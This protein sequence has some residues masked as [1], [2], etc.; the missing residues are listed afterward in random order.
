MTESSEK[1]NGTV[2]NTFDGCLL[3]FPPCGSCLCLLLASYFFVRLYKSHSFH[4][5]NLFASFEIYQVVSHIY[6]PENLAIMEA[7]GKYSVN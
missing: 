4:Q 6:P 2:V 5:H 3:P 7:R 1:A